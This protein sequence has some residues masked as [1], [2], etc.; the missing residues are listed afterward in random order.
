MVN[1]NYK[2][3]KARIKMKTKGHKAFASLRAGVV[4]TVADNITHLR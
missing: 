3:S 2:P 4:A 1:N